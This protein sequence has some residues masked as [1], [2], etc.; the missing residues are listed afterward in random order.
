MELVQPRPYDLVRPF[1]LEAARQ[2]G[3]VTRK[4]VKRKADELAHRVA[5]VPGGGLYRSGG[6]RLQARLPPL[7]T[8]KIEGTT[9]PQ[10]TKIETVQAKGGRGHATS[11]QKMQKSFKRK[12]AAKPRF[13]RKKNFKRARYGRMKRTNYRKGRGR[14]RIDGRVKAHKYYAAT[15]MNRYGSVEKYEYGGRVND[16]QCIYIGHSIASKRVIGSAFRAVVKHLF[17]LRGDDV[18]D[19]NALVQNSGNLKL[20][21]TYVIDEGGAAVTANS[22][23]PLAGLTYTQVS[24]NWQNDLVPFMTG[25]PFRDFDITFVQLYEDLGAGTIIPRS[26]IFLTNYDLRF[27]FDSKL[28]IQNIT[29]AGADD[30][31]DNINANPL[32]GR[33]YSRNKSQMNGFETT[34]NSPIAN[35]NFVANKDTGIFTNGSSGPNG[36]HLKKPPPAWMFNCKSQTP[37]VLA[38]GH[39]KWSHIQFKQKMTWKT[40]FKKFK[41]MIQA[42]LLV[43]TNQIKIN[44]GFAEMFALEKLVDDRTEVNNVNVAWEVSAVYGCNGYIKKNPSLPIVTVQ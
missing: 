7:K 25:D 9:V 6:S 31:A 16:A 33:M 35:S 5:Y 27:N 28:K 20:E 12:R 18:K 15:K 1:V 32:V 24:E 21:Y 23:I 4:W 8:R 3:Q 41:M 10:P 43:T 19:W 36:T 37:L 39:I 29:A 42:K 22:A 26:S 14:G 34:V 11:P 44:F 13:G 17:V 2:A 40:F 38:P 30:S